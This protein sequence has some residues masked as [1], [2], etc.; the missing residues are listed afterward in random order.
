MDVWLHLNE[1]ISSPIAIEINGDG[2]DVFDLVNISNSVNDQVTGR[3]LT[4]YC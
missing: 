2:S 4:L 3:F 1:D